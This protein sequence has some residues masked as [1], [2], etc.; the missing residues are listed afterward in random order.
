VA[1]TDEFSLTL[2]SHAKADDTEAVKSALRHVYR[3][4]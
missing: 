1:M 2:R 3:Y 4:A